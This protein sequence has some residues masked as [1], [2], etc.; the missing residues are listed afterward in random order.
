MVS[1][2]GGRSRLAHLRHRVWEAM[3]TETSDNCILQRL[4]PAERAQLLARAKTLDLKSGDVLYRANDFISQIYFPETA[5]VSLVVQTSDGDVIEAATVGNDGVVG[6][7]A[8]LDLDTSPAQTVVQV[9]GRAIRVPRDEF[10]AA[11]VPGGPFDRLMRRYVAY[12]LRYAH[13]TIACNGLHEVSERA[14]RWLLMAHDRAGG[15]DDIELTQEF[16]AEMLGVRRPSV[17]VVAGSLQSSGFISYSRGLIRILDRSG[18][19]RCA[20]ECYGTTRR[21][22]EQLLGPC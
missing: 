15:R 8:M 21:M 6:L 16:L 20:C 5:V 1:G 17:T 3:D 19:E 11:L 18:L 14:C 10:L 4:D 12:A 7:H 2:S 22:Y 13:Q 9:A